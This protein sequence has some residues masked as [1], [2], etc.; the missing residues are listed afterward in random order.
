MSFAE[1]VAE[2][3]G[4]AAAAVESVLADYGIEP[5]PTAAAPV[6]LTLTHLKFAGTKRR[7]GRD[8][9][10][11]DVEKD[12]G[13]GLWAV[14]SQGT[15]LAGKSSVLFIIRW[16]LTGRNHLTQDVQD[17]LAEVSLDGTV[18]GVPFSVRFTTSAD[19]ID[20]KLRAGDAL[21]A[22]FDEGDFEEVMD[23][24][25]LDRL[26]L[27][28]TPSGRHA[29]ERTKMKET[30]VGSAGR[31]TFPHSTCERR[32]RVC[33]LVTKCRVVSPGR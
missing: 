27:D 15:N 16:A 14:T 4:Q 33:S 3:V 28:P 18:G 19:G 5:Q 24:F 10:P 29:R 12:L 11:F 7:E 25:F 2:R 1:A 32:T 13:P 23:S 9:E 17:W 30:D 26:R 6:S 8:D 31:A 22:E 21:V 20:G